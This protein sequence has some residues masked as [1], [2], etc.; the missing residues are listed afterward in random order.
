MAGH[1]AKEVREFLSIGLQLLDPVP[2]IP[3]CARICAGL[4]G[5]P[6]YR[7]IGQNDL[8]VSAVALAE[9]KPLGM[10]KRRHFGLIEG[11]RLEALQD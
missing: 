1:E 7:G 2:V 3:H 4:S 8:W 9:G 5:R 6:E 11:L 10:R